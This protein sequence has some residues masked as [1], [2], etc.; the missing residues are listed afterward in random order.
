MCS[1]GERNVKYAQK[2]SVSYKS[3][4]SLQESRQ[5]AQVSEKPR[6]KWWLS[7]PF[8]GFQKDCRV[9]VLY[10]LT[11]CLFL[12][13]TQYSPWELGGL[14]LGA[15]MFSNKKHT[16]Y[17]LHGR[18]QRTERFPCVSVNKMRRRCRNAGFPSCPGNDSRPWLLTWSWLG[19]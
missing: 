7:V 11:W 10:L 4:C 17:K 1:T 14:H 8:C 9:Q 6:I 16:A 15:A 18:P 13:A 3:I 2:T 5:P 19:M 12:G